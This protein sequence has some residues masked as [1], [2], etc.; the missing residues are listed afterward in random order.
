M[1]RNVLVSVLSIGILALP[2]LASADWHTFWAQFEKDRQCNQAW[3]LPFNQADQHSV[4]SIFGSMVKKGWEQQTVFQAFH[5]D[6]NTHQLNALGEKKLRWI[7][8]NVPRDRTALFV[9]KGLH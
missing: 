6:Q 9:Q 1:N 3:P 7:L 5:F 8:Q 2:G 4:R